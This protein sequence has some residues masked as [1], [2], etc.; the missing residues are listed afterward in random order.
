MVTVCE[1]GARVALAPDSVRCRV[2]RNSD[3]PVDEVPLSGIIC[4]R[5]CVCVCVFACL[6]PSVRPSVRRSVCLSAIVLACVFVCLT[7]CVSVY[8]GAGYSCQS[9]IQNTSP[10]LNDLVA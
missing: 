1:H 9:Y 4:V 7:V 2:R 10:V 8:V 6:C 3:V 5:I